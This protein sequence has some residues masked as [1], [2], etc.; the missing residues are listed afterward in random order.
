MNPRLPVEDRAHEL[1]GHVAGLGGDRAVPLGL[2]AV[3]AEHRRAHPAA[4]QGGGAD[5][6]P[7]AVKRGH[8]STFDIRHWAYVFQQFP[9]G[10]APLQ[11]PIVDCRDVT[12]IR[13]LTVL[14]SPQ[15][16][17]PPSARAARLYR[18]SWGPRGTPQGRDGR[19][20]RMRK[21][22][23]TAVGVAATAVGTGRTVKEF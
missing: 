1:A 14:R 5:H 10:C 3:P 11:P 17:N 7:A 22:R 2:P 12:P 18:D 20:A 16:G 21:M 4:V 15:I 19:G 9:P 6:G 23:F 8:T 13:A